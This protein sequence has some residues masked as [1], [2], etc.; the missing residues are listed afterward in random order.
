M[1]SIVSQ[2]LGRKKLYAQARVLKQEC[3]SLLITPALGVQPS[4]NLRQPQLGDA[5]RASCRRGQR[6]PTLLVH[7]CLRQH[8]SPLTLLLPLLSYTAS[9]RTAQ[10]PVGTLATCD[11]GVHTP[12]RWRHIACS[13]LWLCQVSPL[14]LLSF[15]TDGCPAEVVC[16]CQICD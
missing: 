14:S 7:H 11:P 10:E 8:G 6:T 1:V 3:Q 2:Q 5:Y 15:Q 13:G 4:E 9:Q 16:K 12:R